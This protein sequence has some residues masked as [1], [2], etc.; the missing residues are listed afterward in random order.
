VRHADASDVTVTISLNDSVVIDVTD[1]GIG[2]ADTV[3]TSGLHNLEVR[4]TS[5]GGSFSANRVN[6]RGTKLVWAA[7]LVRPVVNA[8]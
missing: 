2:I 3:A 6:G 1:D 5:V 8:S 4:A 7:P